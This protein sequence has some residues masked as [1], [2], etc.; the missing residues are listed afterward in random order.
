MTT[1]ITTFGLL[2]ECT[3]S[4]V[5]YEEGGEGEGDPLN[6][7]MTTEHLG[8]EVWSVVGIGV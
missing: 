2:L 6:G 5:N 4:I 3:G 1:N 7:Y 8:A